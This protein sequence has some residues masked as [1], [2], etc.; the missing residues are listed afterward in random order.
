V[1]RRAF[2]LAT[3]A[4][5]TG[6]GSSSSDAPPPIDSGSDTIVDVPGDSTTPTDLKIELDPS[7]PSARVSPALLGQ[8]ELSGALY[9][10]NAV[11]GLVDLMK[12]AGFSEWRVGVGRWEIATQMLPSLTDGTSCAADLA[13]LP[14]AAAAP[15]G[16]TDAS[17]VAARDWFVDDGKPVTVA[18]TLA[19]DRYSLGYVRSVIDTALAFGAK[20]YVD[21]DLMPLALSASRTFSRTNAVVPNACQ[22]TFTNRVSNVRPADTTVFGAAAAG[23]VKRIVEGSGT[24]KGRA[25]THFEVWNEPEFP[26]FWDKSFES[27]DL[28]E[29]VKMAA[30]TLVHLAAYRRDASAPEA[31]ALKF[32]LGSFAVADTA[33][34]IVN[35]FDKA[36]LPD[37]SFLPIDFVSF[38]SYDNDPLKVADDI[39]KVAAARRTSTHYAN[40][41]LAL[42]EWG[43][44]LDGKGWDPKT[45]DAPLHA[46]T[47]LALG[48]AS[49]LDHA[50]RAIFWDYFAGLPF[51]L[52]DHDGKPKPLYW[53]YAML[54]EIVGKG[55]ARLAP[56]GFASGRFDGGNVA[57][58][59]TKDDAGVV[60]VLVVNRSASS[61]T[62]EVA[63]SGTTTT[64]KSVKLF[65]A[66]ASPPRTIDAAPKLPLPPRSIALVSF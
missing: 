23:L 4:L 56:K 5:L 35:G 31:K 63:L 65:D 57:V 13:A 12:T 50:H 25:V 29:W 22:A 16:A 10:M 6:C 27:K 17:L 62:V 40:V 8:Y 52:V 34:T 48:A 11:P 45:M 36:P 41:E 2:S 14:K 15:A 64:P 1:V 20:P 18:M 59:A 9:R 53:A 58:L 3:I 19:D 30:T 60:R 42:S 38:H 55:S 33:V 24:E 37:G 21:I 26:F 66:P 54:A 49:G 61:R 51:G 39:E 28:D 47:V 32:G 44:Q 7:A 43:L 46:A